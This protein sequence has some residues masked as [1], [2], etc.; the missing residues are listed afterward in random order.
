MSDRRLEL[1]DELRSVR[2][3]L[4]SA[5]AELSHLEGECARLRDQ[6]AAAARTERD[7]DAIERDAEAPYIPPATRRVHSAT[8]LCNS[9]M[10][11]VGTLE[12]SLRVELGK[13]VF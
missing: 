7:R 1:E 4:Q 10:G 6:L 13:D 11:W 5:Y 3:L 2:K 8:C 12:D 9:C